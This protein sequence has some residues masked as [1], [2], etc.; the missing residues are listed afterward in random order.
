MF[1]VTVVVAFAVVSGPDAVADGSFALPFISGH[2]ASRG[3]VVFD[4]YLGS[5]AV[6]LALITD[7][8]FL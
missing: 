1:S 5:T 4:A 8:N 2:V 3:M 7:A 6:V